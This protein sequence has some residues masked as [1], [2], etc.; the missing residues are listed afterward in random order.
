MPGKRNP[1]PL[2]GGDRADALYAD[3]AVSIRE[4]LRTQAQQRLRRE[5]LVRRVHLLGAR[6]L[7]EFVDELDR[8]HGLGTDLDRRL[9][10]YAQLN[11]DLLR[12]VGGDRFASA[13]TR[14]VGGDL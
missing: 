8:V 13:P 9:E 4:R 1:A 3:N 11:P 14:L 7:Y 10:R 6:V 2:A 12:A 5:H